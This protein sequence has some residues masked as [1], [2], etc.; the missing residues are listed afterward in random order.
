MIVFS[1]FAIPD[2][3]SFRVMEKEKYDFKRTTDLT[4]YE[5]DSEGPKGRIRKEI[6]FY[7]VQ[8]SPSIFNLA[9]GKLL[10][11]DNIDTISVTGNKDTSKI[12]TVVSEAIIEFLSSRKDALV[13]IRGNTPARTRLFQMWIARM[14][15]EFSDSVI[16]EGRQKEIWIPFKKG[17]A[18][19]AFLI[20]KR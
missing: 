9:L 15:A 2:L 8:Q 5:F 16:I 13:Y 14:F 1:G 19:E 10:E 11:N 7:L 4:F 12:L 6:Q 17:I 20:R 3:Y 18:F